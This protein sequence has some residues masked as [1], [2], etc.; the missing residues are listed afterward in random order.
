MQ[1]MGGLKGWLIATLVKEFSEEVIEFIEVNLTNIQIK[2]KVQGTVNN[3][4]RNEATSD[5]ND[6]FNN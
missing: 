4:N 3:E 1:S 5:L 2:R 6:V